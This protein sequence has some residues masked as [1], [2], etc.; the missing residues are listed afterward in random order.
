MA[1]AVSFENSNVM[2]KR[3]SS[4]KSVSLTSR[5]F[6]REAFQDVQRNSALSTKISSFLSGK[7]STMPSLSKQ[8]RPSMQ[9]LMQINELKKII[10]KELPPANPGEERQRK[11]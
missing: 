9:K 1:S 3:Q 2:K 7:P 6:E 10:V 11:M 8:Q 4:H 5:A